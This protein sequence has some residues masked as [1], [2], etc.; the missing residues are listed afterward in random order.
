[1]FRFCCT[2]SDTV[3]LQVDSGVSQN[4]L[5]SSSGFQ[6]SLGTS[7][8][9]FDLPASWFILGQTVKSPLPF[10]WFWSATFLATCCNLMTQVQ[11]QDVTGLWD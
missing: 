7:E 5:P 11:I 9:L 2:S 1:M 4:R 6:Q 10:L 3:L 8:G